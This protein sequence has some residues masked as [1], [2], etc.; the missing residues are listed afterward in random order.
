MLNRYPLKKIINLTSKNIVVLGDNPDNWHRK[1]TP[2]ALINRGSNS[3]HLPVGTKS[4][5]KVFYEDKG[6]TIGDLLIVGLVEG[7]V[8]NLP[9]PQDGIR[10]IVPRIVAE[11]LRDIR[12]DLLVI[13][14]RVWETNEY[15]GIKNLAVT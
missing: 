7:S 8:L 10:Y 1:G 11:Q 9:N 12:S 5:Y 3:A 15:I 2:L 14:G 6:K 13:H 4:L